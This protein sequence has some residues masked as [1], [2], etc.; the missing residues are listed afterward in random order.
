M[1][2]NEPIGNYQGKKGNWGRCS[3]YLCEIF[4]EYYQRIETQLK[5][6]KD[7]AKKTIKHQR[8]ITAIVQLNP[9]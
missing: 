7:Y 8:F 2:S 6:D 5:V 9:I 3:S 1:L 4:L